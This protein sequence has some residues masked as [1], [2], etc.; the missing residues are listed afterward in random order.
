M[1]TLHFTNL[2]RGETI[3]IQIHVNDF[4]ARLPLKV[5]FDVVV[6]LVVLAP[7]G[8]PAA[9]EAVVEDV[10]EVVAV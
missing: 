10:A 4:F 5:L 7:A 1:V 9:R 2:V 8:V 3:A 6:V